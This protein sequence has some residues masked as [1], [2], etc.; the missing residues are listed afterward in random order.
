MVIVEGL[1]DR[2]ACVEAGYTNAVSIPGGAND[3]N[4]IDFNFNILE[5]CKEIILWFDD[6]EPG[7][8]VL[9]G[10]VFTAQRQYKIIQL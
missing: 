9:K 1:N 10:L 4:W 5:K 7:Q 3:L 6:D 2:L 8:S